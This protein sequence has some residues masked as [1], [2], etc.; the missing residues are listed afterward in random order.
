M[1]AT[2]NN[3]SSASGLKLKQQFGFKLVRII[4]GVL[5]LVTA[6]LKLFDPSPD[7][8]SGLDLLS[9][10]RWRMA[11]IEA[12]ALLGLWLLTG[13][14]PRLLWLTGV[15]CFSLL[16]GVSFNL[17]LEGRST[18]GCF[19]ASMSVSPWY[20]LTLDVFAVCFLV[21]WRPL[22][23]YQEDGSY[24]GN[25]H[26]VYTVVMG[27]IMILVIVFGGMTWIFGSPFVAIHF[28]RGESIAVEP[29][30]THVGD[31][32]AGDRRNF[33]I[34]LSNLRDRPVKILGGTAKCSCIATAELPIVI[35]PNETQQINVEINLGVSPGRFQRSFGLYTDDERQPEITAWFDGRIIESP[36]P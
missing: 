3:E 17:G 29:I 11:A 12:E 32:I 30:T 34:R 8:F 21:W 22:Q 9:S 28:L 36:S 15:L 24:A 1:D 6:G 33:T 14:Y 23:K 35:R 2:I 26:R 10:P 16:A 19:G 20:A 18:C 4:L 13:A 27:V 25:L 7:S 31:V 5:L